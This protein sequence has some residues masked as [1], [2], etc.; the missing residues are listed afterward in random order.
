MIA[1]PGDEN[2]P[3][4]FFLLDGYPYRGGEKFLEQ[5]P[6]WNTFIQ[7]LKDAG[8]LTGNV[9][10][11]ATP[12][13][14]KEPDEIISA[15][16]GE[17]IQSFNPLT[18]EI[19]FVNLTVD[20]VY[21]RRAGFSS[22]VS[23]Y[24]GEKLLFEPIVVHPVDSRTYDDLVFSYYGD[25][26]YL[27]D[28]YGGMS[29]EHLQIREANAQQRKA[30][31]DLFIEYLSDA[32][33]VTERS[34][35]PGNSIP[36]DYPAEIEIGDYVPEG[37]GWKTKNVTADSLYVIRSIEEFR[38]FVSCPETDVPAIDFDRYSLL[39]V[40]GRTLSGIAGIAKNLQQTSATGYV[41][42][43]EI[44]LNAATVVQPWNIAVLTP[45]LPQ[46]A[47]VRLNRNIQ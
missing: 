16:T 10:E 9:E 40:H 15:F 17:D 37:C 19:V 14:P 46:N 39:F 31:W 5:N 45:K 47:A 38:T 43:V 30:E 21:E 42:N 4:K 33:K 1:S 34:G 36:G 27:W 7:Y 25:K 24:I 8:K 2:V 28:G 20:D 22:T 29:D 6:C 44:T 23:F 41:L 26:F 35:N 32:G 18:R 13:V 3:D 11:S 12:V